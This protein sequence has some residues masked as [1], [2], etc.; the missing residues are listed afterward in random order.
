MIWAA[1]PWDFALIIAVLGV[2]VPWRGT[3]R[4]KQLLAQPR[5]DTA[6]RLALYAS[7]I[8]FQ[9][10]A[11]ATIAWRAFARGLTA[12][13][14]AIGFP[15]PP[16]TF[17]IAT[18][19]AV[20]LGGNQLASLRRLGRIPA[21]RRSFLQQLAEKLLP[22]DL[23][24]SLA[25]VALVCTVALCEELIYRGF[26]LNV[27]WRFGHE[28]SFF[29]I[30]VS[31]ALF[32]LAHLYQGPKGCGA[33]FVLGLLFG[34]TRVWTDSLVPGIA[35]HLVVDLIAGLAAPQYVRRAVVAD[36]GASA[37]SQHKDT[38]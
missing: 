33:T 24:E 4:I 17:A 34:A 19:L 27:F 7:T 3:V 11:V 13:D 1:I 16:R 28:S 9:C 25:F 26:L 32:A 31:S 21:S 2:V 5:L 23:V 15:D 36:A 10:A 6:D 8:A 22:Q 29:A 30:V 37:S 12:R 38:V 20:L 35:A 18:A 14:L